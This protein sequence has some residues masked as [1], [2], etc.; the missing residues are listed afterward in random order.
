MLETHTLSW[1]F[2]CKLAAHF[3][4]ILSYEHSEWLPLLCVVTSNKIDYQLEAEKQL[5][6]PNVYKDPWLKEKLLIDLV[7]RATI[8]F[9]N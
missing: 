2:S 7:K 1:V 8:R 9:E 6:N 5:N 4:N 3:Q